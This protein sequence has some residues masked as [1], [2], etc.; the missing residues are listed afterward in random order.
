[1]AYAK[2]FKLTSEIRLEDKDFIYYIL[3]VKTMQELIKVQLLTEK[4]LILFALLIQQNKRERVT[5]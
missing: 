1:M 5:A 4:M 2:N 3:P